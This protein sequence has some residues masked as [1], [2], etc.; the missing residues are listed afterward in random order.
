[1]LHSLLRSL[2]CRQVGQVQI[3]LSV[4]GTAVTP[5][6][7]GPDANIVS[8]VTDLGAGNYK[9]NFKEKFKKALHVSAIVPLTDKANIRVTATDVDSVTVQADDSTT[10]LSIDSD[11]N[12]QIQCMD[13]LSYYF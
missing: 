7:S 8:S 9:I 4:N 6:A 12:I 11:F 3:N 13:Q 5:A 1:M 2:K 10:G